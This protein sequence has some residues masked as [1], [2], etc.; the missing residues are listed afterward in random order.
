MIDIDALIKNPE[1]DKNSF[2]ACS[3]KIKK[4]SRILAKLA[5]KSEKSYKAGQLFTQ[6]LSTY[7]QMIDIQPLIMDPE[8]VGSSANWLL[9]LQVDESAVTGSAQAQTDL[10]SCRW[11]PSCPSYFSLLC[12]K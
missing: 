3:Q 12:S 2:H 8:N 6:T 1:I 7:T 4:T 11:M 5:P 9:F 10:S